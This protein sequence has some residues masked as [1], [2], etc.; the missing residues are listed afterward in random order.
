MIDCYNSIEQNNLSYLK[1]MLQKK[2]NI[3]PETQGKSNNNLR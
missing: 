3:F 2:I 1:V